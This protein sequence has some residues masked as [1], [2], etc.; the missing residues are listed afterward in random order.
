[1]VER[2][3]VSLDSGYLHKCRKALAEIFKKS[4]KYVFTLIIFMHLRR[5]KNILLM[6]KK[7]VNSFVTKIDIN[8]K[9]LILSK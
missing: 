6:V 3:C 8:K 7:S 2:I 4:Y 5:L 1:M 9:I